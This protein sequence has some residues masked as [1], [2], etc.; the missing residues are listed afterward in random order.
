MGKNTKWAIIGGGNGGQSMAGHLAIMG[1]NVRLYDIFQETVDAINS[2]GGVQLSGSVNGFGRLEFATSDIDRAINGADA[3]MVVAPST[4]HRTIAK[5]CAPFLVD[6]QVVIVHPGSTCGA[7]EFRHVL[8]SEGCRAKIAIAETNSLIYAC[9]SIKPGL[10]HIHG[11]KKNLVLA[12]MPTRENPRVLSMIQEA[13]PQISGGKNVLESSFANTNPI[14]HP[15]PSLLNASMIESKHEWLYYY[16]G[17]TPSIGAFVEDMD[18]ERVQVAKS[19][20]IDVLPIIEWYRV[21]YGLEASTLTEA[22]RKNPAYDGIKGQKTLRTRYVLEDIPNGL[23]PLIELGK[24]Q[25]IEMPRTE[26]VARLGQYLLKE[27]FYTNGRTLKNLGIKGMSSKE[28]V[29]YVE[30][31]ER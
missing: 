14:V 18:R 16:E 15:A 7:L 5:S 27:D 26:V 30:T 6:G 22:V 24:M 8:N 19:F 2:Q 20:G 17:I 10:A 28:L 12:T 3:V 25:K 23:V 1:F 31:A 21:T 29:H 13:F 11:I 9:R 4:A